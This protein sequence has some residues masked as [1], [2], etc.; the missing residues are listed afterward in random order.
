VSIR[1]RRIL[2][3]M[4]LAAVA[5][6]YGVA[7][8]LLVETTVPSGLDLPKVN[9]GTAFPASAVDRARD[10]AR[11]ERL[12][13]VGGL[14]TVVVVLGLYARYG[15]RLTRESAAGR[16]GTGML[17]AMLGLGI[18]WLAQIPFG[19]VDL[20]WQ[21][22]HGLS[23]VGYLEWIVENWLGLGGEFLFI[24]FAILIVMALAGFLGDRWW[25]LGG[26]AFVGLVALFAFVLPYLTPGLSPA[27]PALK[28]E[29]RQLART[30]GT[31]PVRVD[32]QDVDAD[33]TA[34]NAE[35]MGLG[36]TRRVV[37]WNTLVDGRFTAK[38][39]RVVLA[40]EVGHLARSH[41]AKS[42]AWYAL[43]ALPGAFLIAWL[44]RRRGGM[45]E[46]AAVPLGLFLFV[47]LGLLALP[48]QNIVTRRLEAEAD[49][50]ALQATRDPE[51][52]EGLFR[53]FA[54]TALSDPSPPTWEYLITSSHP[55]LAQ[56]VAMA[57]AWAE[58]SGP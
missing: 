54:T 32:V 41:V 37:L 47:V 39:V 5:G 51:A 24:S 50:Q 28:A 3:T 44:T 48:L 13:F 4:A 1:L 10:Y 45:R 20:W 12:L 21:R 36:P 8:W 7:V 35:A 27:R 22:R 31:D 55:T 52:V 56:R 43:F 9:V 18:L 14:I 42:I 19:L 49:W 58:R 15:A 16:I 17:L 57:K 2:G 11:V 30:E 29:A 33:T 40:H 34:P 6:G 25:I 23:K 53:R 46:P 38:Q 26:P